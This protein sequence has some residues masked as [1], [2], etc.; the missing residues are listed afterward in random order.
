MGEKNGKEAKAETDAGKPAKEKKGFQKKRK[1]TK[2]QLIPEIDLEF[3]KAS[4]RLSRIPALNIFFQWMYHDGWYA[5]ICLFVLMGVFL[6]FCLN[7]LGQF[8]SVDE[9]KWL[10]D[11]VPQLFDALKNGDW[12]K[13]YINDKP[14]VLPS[15]LAGLTNFKLDMLEYRTPEK[16][17]V[18]L[19]WWRFPIVVFNTLMLP[20][21]YTLSR[22][23][24]DSPENGLAI[25]I[26]MA[27]FP[28]L[29]GA[30]Q[31]VN[32][33][34][35]LWTMSAIT[36]LAYL[37]YIKTG[38]K[39]YIAMTSLF[40]GLALISKFFVTIFYYAF[41]IILYTDYL[42]GQTDRQEF[43]RKAKGLLVIT[44]A[45]IAVYTLLFPATWV[46]TSLIWQG[47]I[48]NQMIWPVAIPFYVFAAAA[49]L[50][51]LVFNGIVSNYARDRLKFDNLVYL[52][53][54]TFYALTFFIV[55]IDILPGKD[56]IR[57][58]PLNFFVNVLRSE[59]RSLTVL[60]IALLVGFV[61]FIAYALRF[62]KLDYRRF[63]F[64]LYAVFIIFFVK[65]GT[66][67]SLGVLSVR[68][69]IILYPCYAI[70]CGYVILELLRGYSWGKW[71]G[72]S[73]I[74]ISSVFGLM[75]TSPFYFHY[76]NVLNVRDITL[77]GNWGYGGYEMAQVFNQ[78]EGSNNLSVWVDKEGSRQF[79][80]GKVYPWFV[81]NP[82]RIKNLD[83][84]ILS[85]DGQNMFAH[86]KLEQLKHLQG[87]PCDPMAQRRI[88]ELTTGAE[89]ALHILD[90]LRPS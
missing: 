9:E 81:S 15:L 82:F 64:V 63:R 72:I 77:I 87:I 27:L 78:I 89:Y 36:F 2:F 44:I 16:M 86:D 71:A 54:A 53:L 55:V 84:L 32:P 11:R 37:M 45:S 88:I 76:N 7:H 10:Y 56:F 49:L 26:S 17:E 1:K 34:A 29:V 47:T 39:R 30:S 23:L 5:P 73:F 62:R 4:P 22:K 41:F 57:Q 6:G 46:S 28:I 24:F 18:Y 67:Y 12:A 59:Q 40:F 3:R 13:T 50:D 68:Y 48:I 35:T 51:V 8:M 74:A 90:P 42:F 58:A 14:G 38:K 80:N 75:R 33:D 69:Q 65:I 85:R 83:Y 25:T 21:I 60:N 52:F 31:I 79:C 70:V 66:A 19:F 61:V 43:A 20:I